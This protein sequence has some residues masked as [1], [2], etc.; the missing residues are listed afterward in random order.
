MLFNNSSGFF[1][2]I[3]FIQFSASSIIVLPEIGDKINNIGKQYLILIKKNKS[4]IKYKITIL[5]MI[6]FRKQ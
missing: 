2:V 5:L 4:S 1:G 3:F 6:Y